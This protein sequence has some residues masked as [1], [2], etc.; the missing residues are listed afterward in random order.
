MTVFPNSFNCSSIGDNTVT[1][2]VFDIIGNSSTVQVI[3]TVED[4]D[5]P[6]LECPMDLEVEVPTGTTYTLPNYW[7][8]EIVTATDNCTN[9]ITNV[10]QT[11][12][13]GT[14]LPVGTHTIEIEVTDDSGNIATCS[15]ELEVRA[16]MEVE[17]MPFNDM[18]IVVYPNPTRGDLILLNKTNWVLDYILIT[19][20]QGKV[21]KE[22]KLD[23]YIREQ[24]ISLNEYASGVYFMRIYSGNYSIM[25]QIIRR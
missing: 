21:V 18:G 17:D 4:V 23:S 3:V 2:T 16:V 15:F 6:V 12:L 25:K 20:V 7:V 22:I 13:P 14:E 11:P 9:P 19:D 5:A 24:H 1:L 10:V 8:E